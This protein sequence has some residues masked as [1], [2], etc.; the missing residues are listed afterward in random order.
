M[1]E[2]VENLEGKLRREVVRYIRMCEGSDV[3]EN[4]ALVRAVGEILD[5]EQESSHRSN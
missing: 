1:R 4:E 5:F 3:G 2:R